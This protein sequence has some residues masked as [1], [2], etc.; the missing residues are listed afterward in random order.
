MSNNWLNNSA[1]FSTSMN[2]YVALNITGIGQLASY[3]VTPTITQGIFGDYSQ[4]TTNLMFLPLKIE[5]AEQT[6]KM[7]IGVS[8]GEDTNIDCYTISQYNTFGFSLGEY[9]YIAKYNDFRDFEPYSKLEIYLPFCGKIMIA[10]KDVINKYI[11]FRLNVDFF[12]GQAMYTI[13]VTEQ[14][15]S[16]SSNKLIISQ[17]GIIDDSNTMVLEKITFQLG[18]TIPFTRSNASEL[19]RNIAI[20]GIK[21]IGGLAISAS[22]T[23]TTERESVT[24]TKLQIGG[25]LKTAEKITTRETEHKQIDM[26]KKVFGESMKAGGS[27]LENFIGSGSTERTQNNLLDIRS[28]TCIKIVRKYCKMLTVSESYK[29]IYGLPL[30]QVKSMSA[31]QGYTE[32]SGIHLEGNGFNNCTESEKRMLERQLLN[33]VIF[34]DPT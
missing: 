30:G 6:H 31:C 17:A 23:G 7:H 16:N 18:Y 20:G 15:V 32:V 11:Q 5:T 12:N 19:V 24:E 34:P 10:I 2:S 8:G 1:T 3:V 22:N 21:A 25:R 4:W 9:H 13:G 26:P 29:K 33:G 27:A 28:N 14:S